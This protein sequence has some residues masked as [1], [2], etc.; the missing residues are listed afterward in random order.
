M[1]S[2]KWLSKMFYLYLI[3]FEFKFWSEE[4]KHVR[5]SSCFVAIYSKP[6]TIPLKQS[7]PLQLYDNKCVL[8]FIVKINLKLTPTV[9][10]KLVV[11]LSLNTIS[12]PP[13]AAASCDPRVG[14]DKTI[15]ETKRPTIQ[16]RSPQRFKGDQRH[17]Y[18]DT[19]I[20]IFLLSYPSSPSPPQLG[21]FPHCTINIC[22]LR[23][24]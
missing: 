2:Y 23:H 24:R 21:W 17:R 1:W 7:L 8:E 14:T 3:Y 10:Y 6:F 12:V 19:D 22:P 11:C 4:Q 13:A 20:L 9:C 18:S 15:I 5:C 16:N